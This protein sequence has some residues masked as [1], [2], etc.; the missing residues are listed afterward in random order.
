MPND[1]TKTQRF[2][3][4][5]LLTRAKRNS[6]RSFQNRTLPFRTIFTFCF[7]SLESVTH[8][9]RD[10]GKCGKLLT[11]HHQNKQ[12]NRTSSHHPSVGLELH[13]QYQYN[14]LNEIPHR[15]LRAILLTHTHTH[16]ARHDRFVACC[17]VGTTFAKIFCSLLQ[18]KRQFRSEAKQHWKGL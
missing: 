12:K 13:Q 6:A 14:L 11:A 3:Y 8:K 17:A 10:I 16:T 1:F 7:F 15:E 4:L 9:R 2:L 18:K 5:L